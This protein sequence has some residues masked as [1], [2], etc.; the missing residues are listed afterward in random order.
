M[1]FNDTLINFNNL[2]YLNDNIFDPLYINNQYISLVNKSNKYKRELKIKSIYTR[3]PICNLKRNINNKNWIYKNIYNHYFCFCNHK[4]CNSTTDFFQS[5]KFYFYISIIDHY[6]NLYNK[7]HYLFSD[8]VFNNRPND[9]TFPVFEEMINRNYPV[10]YITEKKSIYNKYCYQKE[11]CLAI[12]PLN[13][14]LYDKYG[15]FLEK[16]FFLFLKVKAVISARLAIYHNISKLFYDL[17]Y[18]TYIAVGHGVC[19]F[20]YYLY[21][22]NQ[23][24]GINTNNINII[25]YYISLFID[26]YIINIK[27]CLK[28]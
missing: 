12:I 1:F 8:F 18:T 13:R 28:Q 23:I 16:Y 2:I 4:K 11:E 19:Y 27:K 24:Y 5:C 9:D 21:T 6:K 22:E 25:L 14:K 26:L 10:H 15:D 3:Y 17:E 20:K 7:T